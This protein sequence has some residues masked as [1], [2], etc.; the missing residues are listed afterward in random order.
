MFNSAIKRLAL[1]TDGINTN[2]V[3]SGEPGGGRMGRIGSRHLSTSIAVCDEACYFTSLGN[4][5]RESGFS[6]Y[7]EPSTPSGL[8]MD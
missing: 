7:T 3:S 6:A 1:K 5:R 4:Q 8:F 2:S